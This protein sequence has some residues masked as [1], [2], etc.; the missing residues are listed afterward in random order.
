ML[1]YESVK[2]ENRFILLIS[3]A[4]FLVCTVAAGA[5]LFQPIDVLTLD[6]AKETQS[7]VLDAVGLVTSVVGGVE[8]VAVATVALVA[9]LLVDGRSR[10]ALRLVV[11]FVVT[12]LIELATKMVVP[13]P[14]VPEDAMRA[15][16]PSLLVVST[17]H[18]YPSGHMLRS[19]ILLGAIYVLWPSRPGRAALLIFLA[20]AAASRVYLGT[21]WP[22]DVLG[23]AL[24]GIA[25]LAWAFEKQPARTALGTP[26]Q[27]KDLTR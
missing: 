19:V 11:A 25:G 27:R 20:A 21:H 15:Q 13:Q 4:A 22:S 6:L 5:G 9:G 8:F 2:G 10:L 1:I 14:P 3:T 17:P 12:G 24:L 7:R 18:P 16:D 23:G 26:E